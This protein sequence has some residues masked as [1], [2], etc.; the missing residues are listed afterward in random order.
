MVSMTRALKENEQH[1]LRDIART[2]AGGVDEGEAMEF[3]S[4]VFRLGY[5]ARKLDTLAARHQV[6]L[7][8][9]S[10]NG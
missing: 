2:L 7:L 5:V 3:L 8:K 9:G 10:L 4:E 6:Q 1:V